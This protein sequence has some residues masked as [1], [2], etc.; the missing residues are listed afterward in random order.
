MN[1]PTESTHEGLAVKAPFS[2]LFVPGNR[3]DRFDKALSSGADAIVIDLEDAV[4]ANDKALAREHIGAWLNAQSDL[5]ERVLVRINDAGTPWFDADLGLVRGTGIRAIMLPKAEHGHQVDRVR[6]A[7]PSGGFVVPIIESA[8]GVLAVESIA[9]VPAVQRLAFGTLDYA[10][11]LDLSGDERG[12]TYPACR[13]AIAS[14]A[15]G[16]L[17]PIAGV[18]TDIDDEG[19]L[20]ADLA[21]ARACG[22]GAKLCIHPR[23]VAAL[24][25]ALAPRPEEIAWAQRVLSAAN[26]ARGAV[27]VDGQMVDRPVVLKAK[28][29]LDRAPR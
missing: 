21:F 19:R 12:L 18:T 11:D 8:R 15:A 6:A 28:S 29:I 27:Q 26:A 5:G 25:R 3:P 7:L 4:A 13:I 16:L 17:A 22:F 14:R 9:A 23:Q 24:H 1:V 20:L 2:Y 10:L